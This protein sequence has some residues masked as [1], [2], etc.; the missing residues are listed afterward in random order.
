MVCVHEHT[1]WFGRTGWGREARVRPERNFSALRALE[2]GN[3]AALDT[4]EEGGAVTD[5]LHA[6]EESSSREPGQRRMPALPGLLCWL[7]ETAALTRIGANEP[8][9]DIG[10]W[11]DAMRAA[12]K[13]IE[14]APGHILNR[15]LFLSRTDWDRRRAHARIRE[16]A[17]TFPEGHVPQG[18]MCFPVIQ[19]WLYRQHSTNIL[20]HSLPEE[21]PPSDSEPPNPTEQ[22]VCHHD[23]STS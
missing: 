4:L 16:T 8:L 11:L 15:L 20:P 22:S 10:E 7:L 18:F 5:P 13:T 9:P 1:S 14:V 12:A 17:R 2:G 23:R 21:Q 3:A 6:L 19:P